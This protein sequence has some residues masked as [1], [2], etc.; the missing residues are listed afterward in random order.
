MSPS[1]TVL[2]LQPVDIITKPFCYVE[3]KIRLDRA[4]AL[5]C[6]IGQGD[7]LRVDRLSI[8]QQKSDR[9]RQVKPLRP[10]RTGIEQQNTVTPFRLG[11]VAVPVQTDC[12]IG[13][14]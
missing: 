9:A 1:R 8:Q 14:R 6:A 10:G 11:L 2:R 4:S 5:L 12:R 3:Q 7:V 13:S